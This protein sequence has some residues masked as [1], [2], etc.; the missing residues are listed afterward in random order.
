[1]YARLTERL[2]LT[3]ERWRQITELFHAARARSGAA[4]GLLADVPSGC[5]PAPRADAMLAGHDGA[6]AFGE[7]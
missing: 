2:T 7:T 4:S 3:P 1:L 6:G 5:R